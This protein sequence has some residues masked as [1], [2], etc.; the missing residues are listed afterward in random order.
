MLEALA[1][2]DCV[3]EDVDVPEP[4]AE[5]EGVPDPVAVVERVDVPLLLPVLVD[6]WVGHNAARARTRKLAG[7]WKQ[8]E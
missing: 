3:P 7:T 6:V 5:A 1:V 8:M 4:V 2:A